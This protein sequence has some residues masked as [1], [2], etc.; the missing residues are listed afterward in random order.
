MNLFPPM[1]TP[2]PMLPVN[3]GLDMEKMEKVA[4]IFKTTAHPMRIA[5]VQLLVAHEQLSVNDIC[6]RLAT[7]H[8]CPAAGRYLSCPCPDCSGQTC[9]GIHR[10][11]GQQGSL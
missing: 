1:K 7:R 3:L 9:P 11:R 10:C 8:R 4:F 5:I 2:P 6:E